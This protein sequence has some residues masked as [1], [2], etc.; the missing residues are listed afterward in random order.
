MRNNTIALVASA[1]LLSTCTSVQVNQVDKTQNDIS[2]VCIERNP[3]VAVSDFLTVIE[4]GFMRHGVSISVHDLPLPASCEY[5][6]N[7]TAERGW[8]F[9][10]YLDYAELRL[11]R[12]GTTIG[13][14][15]YP[16]SGGFALNKWASTKAKMNPVIDQLLTGR[17]PE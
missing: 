13:T 9:K 4:Q 14:A 8:D 2:R 6:L 15:N 12:N 5:V 17:A 3:K 16:H 10:P 11:S 1:I 7:Y